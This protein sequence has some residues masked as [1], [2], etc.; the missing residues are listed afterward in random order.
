MIKPE[1]ARQLKEAGL[2]WRP[3]PGD[4]FVPGG[5]FGEEVFVTDGSRAPEPGDV[6]LPDVESMVREISTRGWRLM[7]MVY[8]KECHLK[9]YDA[10]HNSA[11][12]T[13]PA[14]GFADLVGRAL[15]FVLNV[16]RGKE[17]K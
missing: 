4:A 2:T 11:E 3:Q 13:G 8:P 15:L 9:V 7:V 12:M 6:W 1:T 14:E 17:K 5:E 10:H 16:E